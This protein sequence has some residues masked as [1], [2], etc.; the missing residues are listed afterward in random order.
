MFFGALQDWRNGYS[1]ACLVAAAAALLPPSLKPDCAS[2]R[3]TLTCPAALPS[4]RLHPSASQLP[5]HSS[6]ANPGRSTSAGGSQEADDQKAA[7]KGLWPGEATLAGA[8][9]QLDLAAMMGGP[10]FRPHVDACIQAVQ[11]M[12][13]GCTHASTH[14]LQPSMR[15]C[16]QPH[17][18]PLQATETSPQCRTAVSHP[19][20]FVLTLPQSGHSPMQPSLLEQQQHVSTANPTAAHP[21]RP[22]AVVA[23]GPGAATL[24][25]DDSSSSMHLQGRGFRHIDS[26]NELTT[27]N[28]AAVL[29]KTVQ[30]HGPHVR[31]STQT[32][33]DEPPTVSA[34]GACPLQA[35]SIADG[36]ADAA[37]K[38]R[39][40]SR[41][42]SPTRALPAGMQEAG[43]EGAASG[44]DTWPC[45][46]QEVPLPEGSLSGTARQGLPVVHLPSFER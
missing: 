16:C 19:A 5:D 24:Q 45:S 2:P 18:N 17:I 37:R 13:H 12:L 26:N 11:S 8:L 32:A 1:L 14:P 20:S 22:P 39:R 46:S 23:P 43:S 7:L 15:A 6:D 38:R 27:V 33:A 36:P 4:D 40:V 29:S 42:G 21:S 25:G 10:A 31:R 34:S 35:N 3:S 28:S 44:S 41:P 30:P 9:L